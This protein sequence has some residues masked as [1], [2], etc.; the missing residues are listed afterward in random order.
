MVENNKTIITLEEGEEMVIGDV[1]LTAGMSFEVLEAKKD[2]KKTDD[3]RAKTDADREEDMDKVDKEDD[4]SEDEK[5]EKKKESTIY[6][7]EED[8][9]VGDVILEKGDRFEI[10]E[11]EAPD[12]SKDGEKAK[13]DEKDSGA[14]EKDSE[15]DSGKKAKD[16]EADKGKKAKDNEKTPE[17]DKADDK[18]DDK[19]DKDEKKKESIVYTVEEE[20]EIPGTDIVLEKGDKF[21]VLEDKKLEAKKGYAVAETDEYSSAGETQSIY[22]NF[23]DNDEKVLWAIWDG[24][25]AIDSGFSPIANYSHLSMNPVTFKD[26]PSEIRAEFRSY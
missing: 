23:V 8:V 10:V 21:T 12:S 11:A 26:I 1:T 19:D 15:K 4:D 5:E 18:K 22:F 2:D 14:K 24:E 6:T 13:D 20:V 7:V 9:K 3:K 17:K 25:R 16:G